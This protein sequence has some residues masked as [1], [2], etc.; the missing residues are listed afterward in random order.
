MNRYYIEISEVE[1][2][3]EG[4]VSKPPPSVNVNKLIRNGEAIIREARVFYPGKH[5]GRKFTA[6][7]I[8]AMAK[9]FVA[10]EYIPIQLGHSVSPKDTVGQV[11]RLYL[12]GIEL[13]ASM[14][15]LGKE[16]VESVT[17]GK[18]QKVSI[19]LVI[20][21]NKVYE[22]SVTSF[23][24][25]SDTQIY[26]TE[27]GIALSKTDKPQK[28]DGAQDS[29]KPDE[30]DKVISLEE[31]QAMKKKLQETEEKV[32]VF[33]S[34]LTEEKEKPTEEDPGKAE[35]TEDKNKM[36]S[37]TEFQKMKSQMEKMEKE[38]AKLQDTVQYDK[39]KDFIEEFVQ[40][41]KTTPAMKD[42]EVDLYHSLNDEQ[43][44]S[45][46]KWKDSQ[47]VLID[48]SV[49]NIRS[50]EK[51]G[52]DQEKAKERGKNIASF[53]QKSVESVDSL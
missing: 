42:H 25:L 30:S 33:E 36:V 53:A 51:P 21:D 12:K 50:F 6:D 28:V 14:L 11:L 49:H 52:E 31:F 23:P 10:G 43:R 15:F 38:N 29:K 37:F 39:D 40:M 45:F 20:K 47:P 1:L 22:I 17:T 48:Y 41:G 32:K 3:S 9:N 44:E 24:A 16:A 27:G 18:W 2:F 5:K 19:G 4:A 13:W 35:M 26:S 34:K 7:D 46:K 8:I